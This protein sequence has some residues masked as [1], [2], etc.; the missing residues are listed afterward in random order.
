M[1]SRHPSLVRVFGLIS[2]TEM[3]L[4]GAAGIIVQSVRGVPPVSGPQQVLVWVQH[5][6]SSSL[7]ALG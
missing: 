6:P 2:K 5:L 4:T 3:L 7:Q 1:I